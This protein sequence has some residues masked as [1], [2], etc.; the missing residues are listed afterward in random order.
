MTFSLDRIFFPEGI[1][2]Q[3][4]G[5]L[6]GLF[7][8]L[9]IAVEPLRLADFWEKVIRAGLFATG[10]PWL[11]FAVAHAT[12]IEQLPWVILPVYGAAAGFWGTRFLRRWREN[13]DL[14]RIGGWRC[15]HCKRENE[16]ASPVCYACQA[17]RP[18]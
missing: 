16:A 6:T 1:F 13:R 9:F 18:T 15:P 14:R 11:I 4:L 2:Y 12:G 3:F 7:L 5:V 17:W 10:I 8:I